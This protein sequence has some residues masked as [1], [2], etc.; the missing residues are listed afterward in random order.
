MK[1][2]IVFVCLVMISTSLLG[3]ETGNIKITWDANTESDL[4]GY[5]VYLGD[6][7]SGSYSIQVDIGNKI[8]HEWLNN[9]L[10][11]TYFMVVTA[12]DLSGN[13]SGFSNEVTHTFDSPDTTPPGAPKGNTIVEVTIN[14]KVKN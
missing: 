12:Y 6:T 7:I 4:A 1:K 11:K 10:G 13:E 3:Q 9:A 8:N 5:K 2:L 14:I